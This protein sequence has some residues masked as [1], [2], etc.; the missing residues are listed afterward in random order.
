MKGRAV[1]EL[2]PSSEKWMA[3]C[4]EHAVKMRTCA[5]APS[6]PIFSNSCR[7]EL[8]ELLGGKDAVQLVEA[9]TRLGNYRDLDALRSQGIAVS[10]RLDSKGIKQSRGKRTQLDLLN[11]VRDLTPVLLYFGVPLASGEGSK[12]VRALRRIA[13]EVEVSGDPRDELR[14]LI[15]LKR[16]HDAYA[17]RV[18]MEAAAKAW[19]PNHPDCRKPSV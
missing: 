7:T 16:A 12:L 9:V 4:R 13:E 18:V 15:K 5:D 3:Y 11:M 19:D 2:E 10:L 6:V 8:A 14:R 17:Y 1:L